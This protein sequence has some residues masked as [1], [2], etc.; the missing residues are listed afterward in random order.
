MILPL[1]SAS[2]KEL[3]NHLDVK[4]ERPEQKVNLHMKHSILQ[5]ER[6]FPKPGKLMSP[7]SSFP[8]E[9]CFND[10]NSPRL[11]FEGKVGEPKL[12]HSA[13]NS[14]EQKTSSPNK[15]KLIQEL[16]DRFDW[17]RQSTGNKG[18]RMLQKESSTNFDSIFNK[19]IDKGHYPRTH[20]KSENSSERVSL[21]RRQVPPL[22]SSKPSPPPKPRNIPKELFQ[23]GLPKSISVN[24]DVTSAESLDSCLCVP[25]SATSVSHSHDNLNLD[26][27]FES[28]KDCVYEPFSQGNSKEE[29]CKDGTDSDRTDDS[30]SFE[31][32]SDE[33]DKECENNHNS[34]MAVQET[35][36]LLHSSSARQSLADSSHKKLIAKDSLNQ[37]VIKAPSCDNLNMPKQVEYVNETESTKSKDQVGDMSFTA[38]INTRS[39]QSD[40]HAISNSLQTSKLTASQR[41][42]AAYNI[43]I[44][45]NEV[46]TACPDDIYDP[47]YE[48]V[49]AK[50][51]AK[52]H[53]RVREPLREVSRGCMHSAND[54]KDE[55]SGATL[56]AVS[57]VTD[58]TD[59]LDLHSLAS[60][61]ALCPRTASPCASP[62]S[63][64]RKISKGQIDETVLSQVVLPA[65]A[66]VPPLIPPRIPA[67]GSLRGPSHSTPPLSTMPR[68]SSSVRTL[69]Q[70]KSRR[71]PP[72][73]PPPSI[74]EVPPTFHDCHDNPDAA[75]PVLPERMQ[76]HHNSCATSR[77]TGR[78]TTNATHSKRPSVGKSKEYEMKR[79][80]VDSGNPLKHLHL[81]TPSWSMYDLQNKIRNRG[82]TLSP[83]HESREGQLS[84]SR[85]EGNLQQ[86]C[87]DSAR[88][89]SQR[90][91]SA[92]SRLSSQSGSMGDV[93]EANLV[94][95]P[96][97]IPPRRSTLQSCSSQ[98][99]S[100]LS[101][102]NSYLELPQDDDY[103]KY[104]Y[105]SLYDESEPL[106][107]HYHSGAVV[108]HV[109][110]Q[111][112]DE[113]ADNDCFY[114]QQDYIQHA[115]SHVDNILKRDS[116]QDYTGDEKVV[117][118]LS[119]LETAAKL[120]SSFR[121]LWCEM[122]K[123]KES[124]IL[125]DLCLDSR[126]LQESIFE[127]L[128]SEASY[129]K[130]LNLLVGHFMERLAVD[131]EDKDKRVLSKQDFSWLFSNAKA[132]RSA[133]IEMLEALEN[134]W[135]QGCV[136]NALHLC[137]A[138]TEV[139]QTHY[140]VYVTYCSN[141][142]Y[143]ERKLK[144]LN[145]RSSEFRLAVRRLEDFADCR[146][147]PL[148][149]FLALPMQRITRMPLLVSAMCR[150]LKPD[151]ASSAE[152][153]RCIHMLQKTVKQC[154]EG[155]R[156]MSNLEHMNKIDK[157][158]DFRAVKKIPLISQSRHLVKK[159]LLV[160]I[161]RE[162]SGFLKKSRENLFFFLFSDLL[163]ITR[164]K[165]DK[166][167]EVMDY[168]PR[169]LIHAQV[170][171]EE[172]VSNCL[173]Y[174]VPSGCKNLFR[175]ALLDKQV[176]FILSCESQSEQLRWIQAVTP[177][178]QN[179]G[180]EV[181]YADWDCPQVQAV[182]QYLATEPDELSLEES[183]I[184]TVFRKMNDGWYEGERI[185][186][187]ERGWFPAS[188]T[189]EIQNAHVR[190][191]NLRQQYQLMKDPSCS[192]FVTV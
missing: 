179:T 177:V 50:Q 125:D 83:P 142:I 98:A 151:E 24:L 42:N 187:G 170:I 90:S 72:P 155:A 68:K 66:H 169:S 37:K 119:T 52:V 60:Q 4:D 6:A 39:Q 63:K 92:S 173:P 154:N 51:N 164:K 14:L 8:V 109:L 121:R 7:P 88:M 46:I 132:V 139:V 87:V 23:Y 97:F 117:K 192:L 136:I 67:R 185:R 91:A 58:R 15:V 75:P 71:V 102:S 116:G 156:K 135:Q 1:N 49:Q 130:S 65:G 35:E 81:T 134:V 144:E 137:S 64:P 190:A 55:N 62:V 95:S 148:S 176:E 115:R 10:K 34:A 108:R 171:P 152:V 122:P 104:L 12:E 70:S 181:I 11:K 22:K 127:I 69:Q 82:Q 128:S 38:D 105:L 84:P 56:T 47:P 77:A 133:C 33:V 114:N 25:V 74:V 111:N 79:V 76:G 86:N 118:G 96:P 165:S 80:E 188:C 191:R 106:Y 183:D 153:T 143:Q 100:Y 21:G 27:S 44:N 40:P 178:E 113:D 168:A 61:P 131:I 172:T 101:E 93:N 124:G 94:H 29:S 45:S 149:S 159:G 99:M 147:L 138:I 182:M 112:I 186:D 89:E 123:V 78:A 145:E 43:N 59:S 28:P 107:Q 166:L 140:G 126:R 189:V 85:S 30:A 158:L 9:S 163:V 174:G 32:D 150:Y 129:L 53:S 41:S 20:T 13:D 146:S 2:V 17:Q 18:N 120:G 73:P 57:N 16:V 48:I 110:E 167:F 157:I 3:K 36:H 31:D 19:E 175:M 184:V 162:P 54:S 180:D 160:H 26:I 103:E 5:P 161:F 141:A